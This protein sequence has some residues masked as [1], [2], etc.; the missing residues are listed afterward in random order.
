MAL[1][2]ERFMENKNLCD[3][4]IA[5][6]I[7]IDR[8]KN[9]VL[10]DSYPVHALLLKTIKQI[11]AQ[12]ITSS[13]ILQEYALRELGFALSVLGSS[14][15]S[16]SFLAHQTE[17]D[18]TLL[19]DD[20]E[21]LGP[22][23]M[24]DRIREFDWSKTALGPVG[25]WHPNLLLAVKSILDEDHPMAVCWGDELVF[26]YNDAALEILGPEW[27]GRR[28]SEPWADGW[29]ETV[30]QFAYVM[31]YDTPVWADGRFIPLRRNGGLTGAWWTYSIAPIGTQNGVGGVLM[32]FNRNARPPGNL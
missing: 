21:G 32:A 15:M 22:S 19:A 26:I 8:L 12:N 7:C 25:E 24:A 27:L 11:A 28:G 10:L 3:I 16:D 6:K 29:F 2:T 30:S 13:D 20:G 1:L 31:E 5:Y 17:Y 4:D 18:G 23:A 9:N 14:L